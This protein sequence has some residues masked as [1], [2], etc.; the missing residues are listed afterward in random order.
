M[1]LLLLNIVNI[2]VQ[3]TMGLILLYLTTIV[4][5]VDN[6]FIIFMCATDNLASPIVKHCQHCRSNNNG[7]NTFLFNDNTDNV[8][9]FLYYSSVQLI[10]LHLQLSIIVC[11][12]VQKTRVGRV[13]LVSFKLRIVSYESLHRLVASQS[14]TVIEFGC[15]VVAV[16]GTLPEE[17]FV[18]AEERCALHL[19]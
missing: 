6:H 9:Q 4:T 7:L 8:R 11:I 16:F 15:G 5:M 19:R 14:Q 12:V 10:I 13:A 3:T 18:V 2:V 1:L 17:S